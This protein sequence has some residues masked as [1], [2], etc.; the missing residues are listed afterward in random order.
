MAPERVNEPDRPSGGA[1]DRDKQIGQLG[2]RV[3]S[4]MLDLRRSQNKGGTVLGFIHASLERQWLADSLPINGVLG[5]VGFH[6]MSHNPESVDIW[7][8]ASGTRHLINTRS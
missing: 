4:M 3:S 1:V 6:A 7:P 8:D 5:E 2:Q